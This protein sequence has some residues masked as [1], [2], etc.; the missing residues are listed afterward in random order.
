MAHF[1]FPAGGDPDTVAWLKLSRRQRRAARASTRAHLA[2]TRRDLTKAQ[3]R[4]ATPWQPIVVPPGD[5]HFLSGRPNQD[6]ARL[7]LLGLNRRERRALKSPAGPKHQ[8]QDYSTGHVTRSAT[9]MTPLL[10]RLWIYSQAERRR[11]MIADSQ[12]LAS[13][14]LMKVARGAAVAAAVPIVAGKM[15]LGA[16]KNLFRKFTE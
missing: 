6:S 12:S 11:Q 3:R 13:S 15:A 7:I 16:V 1:L 14:P 4:L 2:Q 5:A 10:S 8:V 9:R